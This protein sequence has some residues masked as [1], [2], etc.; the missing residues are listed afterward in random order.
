MV[1]FTESASIG[2]KSHPN[3]YVG[4]NTTILYSDD[5]KIINQ[6]GDIKPSQSV[7]NVVENINVELARVPS[8]I[9]TATHNKH[10]DSFDSS[11][12]KLFADLNKGHVDQ[13]SRDFNSE[14]YSE[15]SG[16]HQNNATGVG[17]MAGESDAA[18]KKLGYVNWTQ[19]D[20]ILWLKALLLANNFEKEAIVKFLREFGKKNVTGQTLSK[21]KENGRLV[22]SFVT[23]FLIEN[24]AYPIWLAIKSGID[25]LA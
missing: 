11:I 25:E 19:S 14:L 22:D 12:E 13:T 6:S 10:E 24:Q 2:K 20:V 4:D 5:G 15:G 9:A 1:I 8:N 21:F 16:K 7:I 17:E 23:Q 3:R 18:T